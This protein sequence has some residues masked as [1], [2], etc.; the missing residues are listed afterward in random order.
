MSDSEA[1]D[2]RRRSHPG[3]SVVRQILPRPFS[4]HRRTSLPHSVPSILCTS[5]LVPLLLDAS[6]DYKNVNA[7]FTSNYFALS[8]ITDYCCDCCCCRRRRR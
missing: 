4:A 6:Y 2:Q 8:A 7:S 3:R 5:H 1:N